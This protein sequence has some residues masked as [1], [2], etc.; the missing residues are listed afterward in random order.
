[1]KSCFC[2]LQ[3]SGISRA[4]RTWFTLLDSGASFPSVLC[5]PALSQIFTILGP[6]YP[7]GL[8]HLR[9]TE[10]GRWARV[11][12]MLHASHSINCSPMRYTSCKNA[13]E[14]HWGQIVKNKKHYFVLFYIGLFRPICLDRI[15][16]YIL[17]ISEDAH[18][19]NSLLVWVNYSQSGEYQKECNT[20]T[21]EPYQTQHL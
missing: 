21:T 19:A 6:F 12:P 20:H 11:R 9:F 1:M 3:P 10:L 17:S 13:V 15:C 16:M 14:C 7:R 8:W 5:I 2:P 4:H 18:I